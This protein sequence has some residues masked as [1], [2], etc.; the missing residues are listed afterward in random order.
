MTLKQVW[1]VV[2]F[3]AALGLRAQE[4]APRTTD[5]HD[6]SLSLGATL[7]DG[8]SETMMANGSLLLSGER[9]KLGSFRIGLEGNYGENT[10]R[11]TVKDANDNDVEVKEDEKTVSNARLSG[12]VKKTL[13]PRSY[14]YLDGF[15][16]NDDIADIDYR[17]VV[18]PGL[19]FYLVKSESA[20][21]S[22]ESGVAQVWEEVADVRDDYLAL[23][24]AENFEHKFANNS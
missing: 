11:G 19:G 16:L 20:A 7:T 3:F 2:A 5:K 21:F 14:V 23:R 12:N 1:M 22:I 18:G 8:N 13:T 15:V 6:H 17:A 4:A 24:L 9:E 10:R